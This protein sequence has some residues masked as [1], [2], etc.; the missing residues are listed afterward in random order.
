MQRDLQFLLTMLQ[1]A[2][3]IMTYTA[4]RSKDEFVEDV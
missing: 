4:Q 2:A 3:L 1:S